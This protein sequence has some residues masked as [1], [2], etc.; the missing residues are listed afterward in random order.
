MDVE[1]VQKEGGDERCQEDY[2]TF[3]VY[4]CRCRVVILCSFFCSFLYLVH[5]NITTHKFMSPGEQRLWREG[6][7]SGRTSHHARWRG[8][9]ITNVAF[10]DS[11]GVDITKG[12][13]DIWN[14]YNM[15]VSLWKW[16]I[17]GV[18]GVSQGRMTI[19][20]WYNNCIFM[21]NRLH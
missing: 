11:Q 21:V 18:W 9:D 3:A 5:F 4:F 12:A 2:P 1:K 10:L 14:A 8:S 7:V 20:F 19:N 17:L 6:G 16:P 13:K 15:T